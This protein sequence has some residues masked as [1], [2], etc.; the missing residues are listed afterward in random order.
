MD[1]EYTPNLSDEEPLFRTRMAF[2]FIRVL[3]PRSRRSLRRFDAQRG[4]LAQARCAF[5]AD[6][7][8][9]HSATSGMSS[10]CSET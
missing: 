9:R 10:P 2:E 3:C 4:M 8:Q 6:G 7:D 1:A 5:G